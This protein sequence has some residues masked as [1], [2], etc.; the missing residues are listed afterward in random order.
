MLVPIQELYEPPCGFCC[1]SVQSRNDSGVKG[2][3]Q[4]VQGYGQVNVLKWRWPPVLALMLPPNFKS[5]ISLPRWARVSSSGVG[6]QF[7]IS[8][9]WKGHTFLVL[10]SCCTDCNEL[11]CGGGWGG[12]GSTFIL[13]TRAPVTKCRLSSPAWQV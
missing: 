9:T 13:G 10:F 6:E 11:N 4:A 2:S 1:V 8:A 7:K 12:W 3:F 5:G